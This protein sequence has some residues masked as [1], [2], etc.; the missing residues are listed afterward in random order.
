MVLPQ[1][2]PGFPNAP[3]GRK[4][5]LAYFTVYNEHEMEALALLD[6]ESE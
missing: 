2:L 4:R 6:T 3:S 5:V 1:A